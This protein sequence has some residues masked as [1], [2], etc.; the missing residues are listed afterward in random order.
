MGI[1]HQVMLTGD[2]RRAAEVIARE[3]GIPNVEAELLPEQKLDRVR[4]LVSQG[5][6]VAMVG[7]GIND[8]PALAAASVGIAVAGASDITAE[9]ADVV[10]L[11][12]SLEK[13]PRLFEVSRRAMHTAWQN[14]VLFAG[15]FNA[16]GRAGLRHRQAG[17]DRRRL[18]APALVVLR[19]DEF[20]AAAA[21]GAQPVRDQQIIR[22]AESS[23]AAACACGMRLRRFRCRRGVSLGR[24]PAGN[25]CDPRLSPLRARWC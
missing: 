2:R 23:F 13:L 3:I 4:Q 20:A 24:R 7:D 12:H 17:A 1:T 16:A 19:D 8:A 5:R 9:A 10:Y 11:P 18:H 22:L 21:R 15:A 14:I 6:T 25:S